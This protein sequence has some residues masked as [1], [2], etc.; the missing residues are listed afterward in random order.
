MR[1][2]TT[3]VCIKMHHFREHVRTGKISI[4]HI[5]SKLQLADI[6]PKPQP[7]AL[8]V[9]QRERI[10]NWQA[11]HATSTELAALASIHL[12]ATKRKRCAQWRC[13][14]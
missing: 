4:Q 10:M 6:T 11:E 7:E 12:E 9:D 13:A 5:Q 3:H 8:L 1:P 14:H 2:R